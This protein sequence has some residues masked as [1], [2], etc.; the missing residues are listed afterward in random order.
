MAGELQKKSD[1]HSWMAA[2]MKA[3]SAAAHTPHSILPPAEVSCGAGPGAGTGGAVCGVGDAVVG[4]R[5][6]DFVVGALVVGGL[7]GGVGVGDWVGGGSVGLLVS[8]GK[9]VGSSVGDDP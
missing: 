2:E 5:V 7:V 8:V 1:A 6:G 9:A 3:A 4:A